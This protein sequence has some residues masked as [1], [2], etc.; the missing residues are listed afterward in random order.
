[1]ATSAPDAHVARRLFLG[2]SLSLAGLFVGLASL[3]TAAN[4]P[5]RDRSLAI[6]APQREPLAARVS[7][8]GFT[9]SD[10]ERALAFYC[11]VLEMRLVDDREVAGDAAERLEGVFGARK[12]VCTLTLGDERVTL[13]QYLAPEG[14]PIPADSRSN[15]GWFQ[16]IAIVVRDMDRAYERLRTFH[17]RHASAGPQTIPA[18]NPAA[19]GI[20]AFYFKDPDGHVLEILAFPA[21]KGDPRWHRGDESDALFL[22]IDHTAIAVRDTDASLR[23]YRDL[24]GL[25]VAGES[26]NMGVEQ[27]RLN[28]VEGASLRITTLRPAGDARSAGPGIELLEYL[29]P[30][31]GRP[32]PGDSLANDVWHWTVTIETPG[33][34]EAVGALGDGVRLAS[35][36]VA[37]DGALVRDP[38]GHAV[39]LVPSASA[40]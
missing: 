29:E 5:E 35:R 28:N 9:V 19:G 13:T 14:R 7:S 23:F 30:G 37:S 15:D 12:R 1:M 16:H 3:P 4:A 31:P 6:A 32:Y 26:R 22:G 40:P 8:V 17:V 33:V 39:L 38:D 34:V 21:D 18:S 24:L 11:G 36:G 20:R 10:M 25:H 2:A 27:A